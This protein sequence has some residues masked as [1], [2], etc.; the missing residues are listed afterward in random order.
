MSSGRVRLIVY[1]FIL[2]A[3][4]FG[5]LLEGT[6]Q[7]PEASDK[8]KP[9]RRAKR[10]RYIAREWQ[11]TYFENLFTEGLVGD[12][13]DLSKRSIAAAPEAQ[14]PTTA[15]SQPSVPTE[16]ADSSS[17]AEANWKD[18]I[19]PEILED[20]IKR[21]QI[22][23]ES[24]VTTPVK[25]KTEFQNVRY[26]FVNLS[27]WL[28]VVAKHEEKVRWQD[29][30]LAAQQLF[31]KTA[32]NCRV[33]SDQA[34]QGAKNAQDQLRELVRGGAFTG[35]S[36]DGADVD[37]TSAVDRIPMMKKLEECLERTKQNSG[38]KGA[39]DAAKEEVLHDAS[40]IAAMSKV[41]VQPDVD[42]ADD[43]GYVELAKK[44]MIAAREVKQAVELDNF[45]A[46]SQAIN[47][48]EQS[49]NDCHGEWR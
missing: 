25:F 4:A 37:W 5:G 18:L 40:L 29:V 6:S 13:P 24:Q 20:E 45:E 26:S 11:G 27:M 17:N 35:S 3:L 21:L 39:F 15:P 22:A 16:N 12:P 14:P 41:L 36:E 48:V 43:E 33:V 10:P 19:S 9:V 32:A 49:C 31:A 8:L 1:L 28:A 44:M 42:D 2:P 47:K 34:F 7:E 38:S 46:V 30:A 23:L